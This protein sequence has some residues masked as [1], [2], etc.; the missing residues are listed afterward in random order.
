LTFVRLLLVVWL[1]AAC[2]APAATPRA[3]Q[4]PVEVRSNIAF[5]DYAG[6]EACRHCHKAIYDSWS[7]SPMH[8]MTRLPPELATSDAPFDGVEFRFKED[9]AR[10]ETHDGARY[11]RVDSTRFG[12][13]LYRVTRAIGGHHREDFVGVEMTDPGPLVGE[14]KNERVLPVSFML[15]TRT[16]RYKG[17]SVMSPERPGLKVGG[18]WA[19]TCIFCHNTVPYLSTIFGELAGP[20]TPPYQGEVVDRLLPVERRWHFEISNP[21]ALASALGRELARLGVGGDPTARRLVDVTRAR[22]EAR[23]LVEVGIGCESCHGGSREHVDN[24]AV[25]PSFEVRSPFLRQLPPRPL[26]AKELRAQRINRTCARCHQVLFSR[27]PFTWEAGLRAGDPGG[28]NINSGEGR[29][30]LL[31]GCAGAMT[32]VDCHD[33]HAP[34]NRA[35]MDAL[36]GPAGNRVCIKCHTKYDNVIALEAHSHHKASGAAGACMSCHMPKKNMSLD[37]RLSRYHRIGSPTDRARVEGDRP[38]ECALCHPD[39]TVA[40]LI[41]QME[42]WWQKRYDRAALEKLYGSLEARPLVQALVGGH[43]HEQA[44]ALGALRELALAGADGRSFARAQATLIAAQLTHPYPILRY[45]ALR[46]LEAAFGEL[47]PIDVHQENEQIRREAVEWLARHDVAPASG[48]LPI[49]SS[50]PPNDVGDD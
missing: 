3:P 42:R 23:H 16:W 40:T 20:G 6:S 1:S 50:P 41:D 14:P 19:K 47:P 25:A 31:G 21:A 33:P 30:L 37:S 17:Y 5:S 18:A 46:A 24:F 8:H 49:G 35:R 13:H 28:S 4:A 9:R 12:S 34:D 36:E 7:S 10:M 27:Y 11:V 43:A 15:D 45:Y 32:C 39:R 22:F 38:L 2:H 26:A 48:A 44:T 29:D